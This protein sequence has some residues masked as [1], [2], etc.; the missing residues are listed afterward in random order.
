MFEYI[1]GRNNQP[2]IEILELEDKVLTGRNYWDIVKEI[3]YAEVD[4]NQI[5]IPDRVIN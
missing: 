3:N 2:S 1:I 4:E 5:S